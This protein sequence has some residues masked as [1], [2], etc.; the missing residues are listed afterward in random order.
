MPDTFKAL[1]AALIEHKVIV[2]PRP[3]PRHQAACRDEP[4]VRRA[5]SAS[6]AAAGRVPGNPGARQPQGQSGAVDRRLAHRH[7]VPEEP[8]ASYTILRCQIMPKVGGDTLWADMEAAYEG[9][10]A[11]LPHDDRRAARRARLQEFP[12]RPSRR[13]TRAR[14]KLRKMEE[15]FPN[16]SHPVVRTHPVTGR[17]SLYVNP[18]FT[19][20]IEGLEPDESGAILQVLYAQAQ[21]PEYQFRVRWTRRRDRV[22]GQPLD[23]ALRRQRLLPQPPPHGAHRGGRRRA[24]VIRFNGRRPHGEER[25]KRVRL[26]PWPHDALPAILRDA[27]LR[28]AP[29]DEGRRVHWAKLQPL[30]AAG[31]A[32]PVFPAAAHGIDFRIDRKPLIDLALRDRT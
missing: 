13:P 17:K 1:E 26:E 20:R 23:P 3:A 2:H 5:R 12:R 11:T 6:D 7:D 21:V 8:D 28:D 29:Q 31:L 4:L 25:A 15:M 18:Q 30:L 9:L 22:L 10:S 19:L 32:R 14:R 27:S 24:G 16:P